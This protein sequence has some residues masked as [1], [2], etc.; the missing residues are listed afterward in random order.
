MTCEESLEVCFVGLVVGRDYVW[1][2]VIIVIFMGFGKSGGKRCGGYLDV[3]N[4]GWQCKSQ[5]RDSF[6]R[7]GWF[8]LCNTVVL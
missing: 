6:Y 1:C 3:I 5:I 8:S 4:W 2:L 7:E